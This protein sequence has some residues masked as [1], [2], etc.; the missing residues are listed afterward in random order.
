MVLGW[1]N[2]DIPT[3][4]ILGHFCSS[5]WLAFEFLCPKIVQTFLP[6]IHPMLWKTIIFIG[7]LPSFQGVC[8]LTCFSGQVFQDAIWRQSLL[9]FSI[10]GRHHNHDFWLLTQSYLAIQKNVRRQARAIFAWYPKESAGYHN[11]TQWWQ[12]DNKWWIGY[13]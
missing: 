6:K 12:C 8:V 1:E 11:D 9:K 3:L 13:K 10:S 5:V 7:L 4:R 2:Y